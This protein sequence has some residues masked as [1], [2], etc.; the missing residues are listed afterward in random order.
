MKKKNRLQMA[1]PLNELEENLQSITL[2]SHIKFVESLDVERRCI[3]L[4]MD[5]QEMQALEERDLIFEKQVGGK[6]SGLT[7][8]AKQL[9]GLAL[10]KYF[11]ESR[12]IEDTTKALANAVSLKLMGIALDSSLI[13]ANFS[14]GEVIEKGSKRKANPMLKKVKREFYVHPIFSEIASE[15]SSYLA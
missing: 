4:A 11:F 12:K 9:A 13:N 14:T 1:L 10:L 8:K 5:I 15:Q 7:R 2:N 3:K 6:F